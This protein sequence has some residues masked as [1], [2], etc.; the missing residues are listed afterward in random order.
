MVEFPGNP[1]GTL[2]IETSGYMVIYFSLVML[3]HVAEELGLC[4]GVCVW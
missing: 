1:K 3:S 4:Q 2:S